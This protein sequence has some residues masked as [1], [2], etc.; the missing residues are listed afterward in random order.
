ME[1]ATPIYSPTYLLA[2][3]T[4][5]LTYLPSL[6]AFLTTL[7]ARLGVRFSGSKTLLQHAIVHPSLLPHT[8]QS[9]G[10]DGGG[11]GGGGGGGGGGA[12]HASRWREAQGHG[13]GIGYRDGGG[14]EAAESQF[15]RLEWLGDAVLDLAVAVHLYARFPTESEFHLTTRERRRARTQD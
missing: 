7:E 4:R 5:L 3:L 2:F 10:G 12:G 6:L 8:R 1:L 15:E 13:T 9:S 11:R 14:G